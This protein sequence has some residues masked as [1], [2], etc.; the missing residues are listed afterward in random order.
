VEP[1]GKRQIIQFYPGPKDGGVFGSGR[2][3]R[4][5]DRG[6]ERDRDGDETK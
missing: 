4:D 6:K 1:V 5:R 2:R 3:G